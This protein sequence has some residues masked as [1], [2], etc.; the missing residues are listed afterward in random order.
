MPEEVSDSELSAKLTLD[1]VSALWEL[2]Y[3]GPDGPPEMTPLEED[4]TEKKKPTG[5]KSSGSSSSAT[6][7]SKSSTKKTLA[8]AQ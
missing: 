1:M 6:Q 5:E 4:P 3:Y 8:A 7:T 2:L